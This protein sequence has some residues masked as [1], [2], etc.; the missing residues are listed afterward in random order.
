MTL[1][2]FRPTSTLHKSI[3]VAVILGVLIWTFTLGVLLPVPQAEAIV[4]TVATDVSR[5][6]LNNLRLKSGSNATAI[7]KIQ[8]DSEESTK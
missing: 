3:N 7:I 4:T 1:N 2:S 5:S 8:F 6:G